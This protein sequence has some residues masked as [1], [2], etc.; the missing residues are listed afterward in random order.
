MPAILKNKAFLTAVID[1][2]PLVIKAVL[3]QFWPGQ[4]EFVLNIW[5]AIQPVAVAFA[6]YYAVESVGKS[7]VVKTIIQ[8]R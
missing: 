3:D 2:I 4:Q 5:Y 1:A 8:R 7:E 6:L